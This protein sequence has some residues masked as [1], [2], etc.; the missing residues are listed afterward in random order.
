M[1]IS[2]RLIIGFIA[3]T[4]LCGVIGAVS[5][6]CQNVIIKHNVNDEFKRIKQNYLTLIE[7][8]TKIL[9]STLEVFRQDQTFK[10]IYLEKNREKLYNYGQPLFQELKNKYGITH[11]YFILPDGHCFVRL[12]NKD[13][14]GD[15]I[16]RFTFNMARDTKKIASGIEL[17]KTAFALRV[18]M[19]Y[20]DGNKLIGYVELGEEIEHFLEILK[21]D[22]NNQFAISADKTNFDR[23]KWRSVRHVAGLSDNWDDFEKHL[24][25]YQNAGTSKEGAIF[26][27]EKNLE[28]IEKEEAFLEKI[29]S[30]DKTFAVGGFDI[31]DAGGRKAG[32]II[33]L[34]DIT[35]QMVSNFSAYS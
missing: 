3:I 35:E 9:S 4:L 17:G 25:I 8:D 22:N 13:I 15:L 26:L 7:R 32:Q 28:R 2:Q 21:G 34:I 1:K 31:V 29:K 27:T 23:E 30:K 12:H 6:Y 5:F 19:P 11:F 16:D 24:F 18:V 20:Y 33:S 10:D 14:F